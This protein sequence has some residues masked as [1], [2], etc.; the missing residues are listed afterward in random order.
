M[1]TYT[2]FDLLDATDRTHERAGCADTRCEG[3]ALCV[4]ERIEL[5]RGTLVFESVSS[6]PLRRL[7]MEGGWVVVCEHYSGGSD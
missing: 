2:T 7:Q 4:L 1:E 5:G 6:V 3:S